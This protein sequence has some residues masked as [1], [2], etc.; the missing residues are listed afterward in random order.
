MTAHVGKLF[1]YVPV[2]PRV[3]HSHHSFATSKLGLVC[4]IWIASHVPRLS[5]EMMAYYKVA[6]KTLVDDIAVLAGEKC[7][8]KCISELLTSRIVISLSDVQVSAIAAESDNTRAERARA[9]KEH[10]VLTKARAILR[11]LDQSRPGEVSDPD[12]DPGLFPLA[13]TSSN[14]KMVSDVSSD[15]S[16]PSRTTKSIEEP[17]NT[18]HQDANKP[19]AELTTDSP[20]W[21]THQ[22][23][24][25]RTA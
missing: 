12:N 3:M 24:R 19:Q 11:R 6:L 13:P 21:S 25:T 23:C 5:T 2:R 8:L 20:I 9:D 10:K 15:R 22:I 1:S 18:V 4:Q 17:L 16:A 7:L 14:A